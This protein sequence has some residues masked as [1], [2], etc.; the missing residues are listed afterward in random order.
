MSLSCMHMWLCQPKLPGPTKAS[1]DAAVLSLKGL[2]RERLKG[3]NGLRLER[4]KACKRLK[5]VALALDHEHCI[6][7]KQL[8]L[9]NTETRSLC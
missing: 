1:A 4:L 3:F 9:Y 2:K 6:G 5:V 8:P 7:G